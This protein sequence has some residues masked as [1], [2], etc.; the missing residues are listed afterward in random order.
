M[1]DSFMMGLVG[2]WRVGNTKRESRDG[3]EKCPV[4][5]SFS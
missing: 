4:H 5:N 2:K 1:A 3:Q